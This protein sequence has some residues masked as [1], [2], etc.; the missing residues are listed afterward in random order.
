MLG[1]D[2]ERG[3][4]LDVLKLEGREREEGCICK[5]KAIFP[6]LFTSA[7]GWLYG[8]RR[9]RKGGKKGGENKPSF[10]PKVVPPGYRFWRENKYTAVTYST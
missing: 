3:V 9:G 1:G 2:E 6:N 5:L 10:P 8:P 7:G 4:E